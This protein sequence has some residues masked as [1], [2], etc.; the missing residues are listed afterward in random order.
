MER[1]GL[2]P[3]KMALGIRTIKENVWSQNQLISDLLDISRITTGKLMLDINT[4][5]VRDVV[6][7]AIDTLRLT[8]EQRGISLVEN[9]NGTDLYINADPARLKQALVNLLSNALKFTPRG[10]SVFITVT[11]RE[12]NL[13]NELSIEIRDTGRGIKAEFLPHLFDMFSQADPSSIRLHGGMGLGLS[14]VKSLIELQGGTVCGDSA[15]EGKGATFTVTLP[16]SSVTDAA[17]PIS[18]AQTSPAVGTPLEDLHEV[19]ILLVEDGEKTREAL[20]HLLASH[21]ASVH[22]AASAPEAM[23][24]FDRE[25]PDIIV[26][27][28]AMPIE[29]GHSLLR[30]IRTTKG[31]FGSK[32]PAIALTAFAE[33]KDRAEAFASGFQEYLAKPVDETVLTS[34]IARLVP[35]VRPEQQSKIPPS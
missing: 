15:G 10:G 28:I 34:T 32:V 5:N 9:L 20:H 17:Y 8:S 12:E 21:G 26:S 31:E 11:R 3:E 30:R 33:P 7:A 24:A 13:G 14:L 1:G 6:I 27:D 23:E 22:S 18:F 29:D 4:I 16:I 2:S 19:K 25:R 35:K